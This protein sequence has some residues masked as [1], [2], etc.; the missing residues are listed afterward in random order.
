MH[1]MRGKSCVRKFSLAFEVLKDRDLRDS[2]REH[3]RTF[4]RNLSADQRRRF[5]DDM[6]MKETVER[7]RAPTKNCTW[8]VDGNMLPSVV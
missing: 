8:Y 7:Q 1:R 3:A 4:A 6:R 5:R 2:E